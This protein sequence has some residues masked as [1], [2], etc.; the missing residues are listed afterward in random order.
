MKNSKISGGGLAS[1]EIRLRIV[2]WWV[3]APRLIDIDGLLND[4]SCGIY[5]VHRL[6]TLLPAMPS[7][8]PA[9]HILVVELSGLVR[10]VGVNS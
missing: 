3:V 4:W 8:V 9:S 7:R 5:R 6:P 1:T 2:G 10:E